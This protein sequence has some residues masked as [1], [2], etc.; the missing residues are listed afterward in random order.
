MGSVER[1]WFDPRRLFDTGYPTGISSAMRS[2]QAIWQAVREEVVGFGASSILEIGPG[3]APVAAGLSG[4]VFLDVVPRFLAS[5]DGA[6]V[7]ADL[8]HAPFAP[9]SFDL[10]VASDVL[11]HVRPAQRREALACVAELGRDLLVFNPEAGTERVDGSPVPSR[12]V[13]AFLEERGYR[14]T[15]RKF[16]AAVAGGEYSMRIVT[17]R[18]G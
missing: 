18:R 4:V 1:D 5:L 7:V 3:D 17:G 9:G 15:S 14:V 11:T 16:V 6:R 12:L 8:F 2:L 10:V 13:T